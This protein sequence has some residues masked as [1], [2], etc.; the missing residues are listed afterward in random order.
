MNKFHKWNSKYARQQR[1]LDNWASGID[2]QGVWITDE[3]TYYWTKLAELEKGTVTLLT[4]GITFDMAKGLKWLKENARWLE[5]VEE[6]KVSANKRGKINERRTHEWLESK[7]FVVHTVRQAQF[8]KGGNDLFGL[9]DH[10][11]YPGNDNEKYKDVGFKVSIVISCLK[12]K[13]NK[14]TASK[15]VL[16]TDEALIFNPNDKVWVQT[17][18]N[19]RPTKGN[20]SEHRKFPGIKLW[21]NWVT[22]K[23]EPEIYFLED[24]V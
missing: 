24:N 4:S 22:D 11:C 3:D 14:W 2:G 1:V 5:Q 7:G 20:A 6:K 12:F 19:N 13:D 15:L 23:E 18:T 16:T 9:W 8:G 10:V 17:K 21:F